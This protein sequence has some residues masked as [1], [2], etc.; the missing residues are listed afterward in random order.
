MVFSHGTARAIYMQSSSKSIRAGPKTHAAGVSHERSLSAGLMFSLRNL[1][2]Y[3]LTSCSAS[4]PWGH[5]TACHRGRRSTHFVWFLRAPVMSCSFYSPS[6]SNGACYYFFFSHIF[7]KGFVVTADASFLPSKGFC[8]ALL[9]GFCGA[10]HSPP[11]LTPFTLS[12]Q[13]QRETLILW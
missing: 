10:L 2:P 8:W 9:R 12:K 11:D 13:H 6:V 3:R 4:G 7:T 1:H 5:H